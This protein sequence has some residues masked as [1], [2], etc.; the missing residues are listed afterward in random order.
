MAMAQRP[1]PMLALCGVANR[2]IAKGYLMD[3]QSMF[4]CR[5]L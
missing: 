2:V 1:P 5:A 4:I 3:V